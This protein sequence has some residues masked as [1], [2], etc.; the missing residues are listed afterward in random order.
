MWV[1]EQNQGGCIVLPQDSYQIFTSV[2]SKGRSK[3]VLLLLELLSF[4]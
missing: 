2:V 4:N 3:V 1:K